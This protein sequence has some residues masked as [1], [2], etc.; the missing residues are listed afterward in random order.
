[1]TTITKK[2][3]SKKVVLDK[4]TVE[5]IKKRMRKIERWINAL[6]KESEVDYLCFYF[7]KKHL[8]KDND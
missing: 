4:K 6:E 3:S 7:L 2:V 8:S 1:M 5:E